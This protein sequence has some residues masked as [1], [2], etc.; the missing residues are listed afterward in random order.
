LVKDSK[1][2][3]ELLKMYQMDTS[4]NYSI[5]STEL[6]NKLFEINKFKLEKPRYLGY[7]KVNKLI[8]EAKNKRELNKIR[9][10]LNKDDFGDLGKYESILFNEIEKAKK[11]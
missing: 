10:R 9:T 1:K 3:V 5:V 2:I 6:E 4:K 8:I 11:N 7:I